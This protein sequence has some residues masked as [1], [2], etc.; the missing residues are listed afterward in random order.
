MTK[1]S[2]Q[3]RITKSS[4]CLA[5][6]LCQSRTETAAT[7]LRLLMG[8]CKPTVRCD[9]PMSFVRCCCSLAVC[10]LHLRLKGC[11]CLSIDGLK[12]T[13]PTTS[14]TD[15]DQVMRVAEVMVDREPQS[16][17]STVCVEHPVLCT[18]QCVLSRR[19]VMPQDEVAVRPAPPAVS[20]DEEP[21]G[22]CFFGF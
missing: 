9:S 8:H 13:K 7:V 3:C 5:A 1:G 12:A 15:S 6:P 21:A 14:S 22:A 16:L 10:D 19:H 17:H 20:S 2:R 4:G 11:L 18:S